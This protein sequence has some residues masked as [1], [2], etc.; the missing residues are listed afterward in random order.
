MMV[1]RDRGGDSVSDIKA[2]T[3]HWTYALTVGEVVEFL[4]GLDPGA[5]L[6][7]AIPEGYVI[8]HK[9]S[10]VTGRLRVVTRP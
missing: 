5:V 3:A 4:Q 9:R 1:C 6:V 7:E 8:E 10:G 2:S